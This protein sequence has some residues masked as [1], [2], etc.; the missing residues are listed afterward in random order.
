M[1]EGK[2]NLNIYLVEAPKEFTDKQ[3]C[4]YSDFVC[5]A[6]SEEEARTCYPGMGYISNMWDEEEKVMWKNSW[7]GV[8]TWIGPWVPKSD[9]YKLK[10]TLLGHTKE[11]SIKKSFSAT[12]HIKV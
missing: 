9:Q 7:T 8:K 6:E 11:G 3:E 2:K 1:S 10:V 4:Y 5:T 12:Y